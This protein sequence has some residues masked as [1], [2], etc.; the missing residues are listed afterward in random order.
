MEHRRRTGAR[1][2]PRSVSRKN[3]TRRPRQ[4]TAPAPEAAP[5]FEQIEYLVNGG[6]DITV[7]RIGP[8]PCAAT[9][10]T[11]EQALAM[12]VR[13]KGETILQLLARLDAAIAKAQDEEIYIDEIN[14]AP[15]P[16]SR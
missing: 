13:R 12:L 14:G 5:R 4:S 9:A 11:E 8:I 6:G 15:N 3:I 1:N 2:A 7:G 16:S 10:A